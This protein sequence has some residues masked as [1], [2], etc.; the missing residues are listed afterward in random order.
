MDAPEPP[1][2]LLATWTV[3]Q[4]TEGC[5]TKKKNRQTTEHAPEPQQRSTFSA[6]CRVPIAASTLARSAAHAPGVSGTLR[7]N[8]RGNY[9]EANHAKQPKHAKRRANRADKGQKATSSARECR[10]PTTAPSHT[11]N[12]NTLKKTQPWGLEPHTAAQSQVAA[13]RPPPRA[14]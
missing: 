10:T 11:L 9:Q 8:I 12:Q 14:R 4:R 5:H 7:G 13:H 3:T 2:P 6:P 1:L